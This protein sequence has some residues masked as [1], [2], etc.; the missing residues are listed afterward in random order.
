MHTV[1][2]LDKLKKSLYTFDSTAISN[3]YY[4]SMQGGGQPTSLTAMVTLSPQP[5]INQ[6]IPLPPGQPAQ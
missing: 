3:I 1:K 6:P 4:K 2:N 5:D